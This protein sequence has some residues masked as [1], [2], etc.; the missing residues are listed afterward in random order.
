M[1]RK[2]FYSHLFRKKIESINSDYWMLLFAEAMFRE[3]ELEELKCPCSSCFADLVKV[4]HII[5]QMEIDGHIPA[6]KRPKNFTG[7]GDCG[8]KIHPIHPRA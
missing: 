7:L 4:R 6:F 5:K 1:E 2:T 3:K 8:R